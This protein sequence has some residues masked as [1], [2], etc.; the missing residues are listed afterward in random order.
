MTATT[1]VDDRDQPLVH[2][3]I[4]LFGHRPSAAELAAYARVRADLQARRPVRLK[5]ARLITR[6]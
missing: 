6:L 4:R 5:M 2:Q 1:P 3:F